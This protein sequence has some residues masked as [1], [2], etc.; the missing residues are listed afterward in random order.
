MTSHSP[1]IIEYAHELSSKF[2]KRH[3]TIYLSNTFGNVR[4]MPDWSW[5]QITADIHTKTVRADGAKR[6]PKTN[7]YFEDREAYD[8]FS[9]LLHRSP[10]KKHTAPLPDITLGCTNF[11]QLAEKGISEFCERSIICLDS[12]ARAKISGKPPLTVIFLPGLLPPDQLIFEYLFNLPADHEFWS[13]EIQFTRDVLTN[14][15]SEIIR[16]LGIT[17]AHVDLNEK[18]SAYSGPMKAR[19]LFKRFYKS[20]DLQSVLH[21]VSSKHNPWRS[22]IETHA[23]SAEEFLEAFR[24]TLIKVGH[25]AHGLDASAWPP[26]RPTRKTRQNVLK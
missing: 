12:D 21:P 20:P 25:L 17:G 14:A 8:F 11:I 18:I 10:L 9:A 22:W 1:T 26:I 2:R 4:V 6:L 5:H 23:S 15:A 16:E 19:E 13:N 7:V 3:K 24:S